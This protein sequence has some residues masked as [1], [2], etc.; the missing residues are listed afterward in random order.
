MNAS[1]LLDSPAMGRL[2]KLLVYVDETG[3]RGFSPKSSPFFAMTAL[4]VPQEDDTDV[5]F[6]AGGLRTLVGTDKPLHWVD[7]FKAKHADRRMFAAR[8]L[9]LMPTVK[10]VHVITPKES[11]GPTAGVRD[12]VRFYNYTARLLLERVAHAARE[13]PGGRRLAVVRLGA[14]RG[15]DHGATANYL[16]RVRQGQHPNHG[17]AWHHIKW[18]LTWVATNWDG[19]QLADLHAGLLNVALSGKPSDDAC[20][21]DLLQC[22]S[23]LYRP[24][25]NG[26]LLG[27]GMKV[28]GDD[29]FVTGRS[30]WSALQ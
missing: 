9:A 14:V 17:V 23:Q 1:R 3:D 6:T 8:K 4:M 16:D 12:G 30:W 13:W 21:Q 26:S 11:V 20:A 10:L 7:H 2:P 15:M 29:R 5:R 19:L 25:G 27:W 22:R 18:P 28:N 24:R